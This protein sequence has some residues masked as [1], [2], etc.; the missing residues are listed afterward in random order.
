MNLAS[1]TY[2]MNKYI[3][4]LSITLLLLMVNNISAQVTVGSTNPPAE[5]SVLQLDGK[6][7]A[8]RLPQLT[9]ANILN[10]N[11]SPFDNLAKGLLIYNAS[12]NQIECWNGTDWKLTTDITVGNGLTFK[13]GKIWLGGALNRKTTINLN[14]YTLSFLTGSN[15]F[16][17]YNGVLS[18]TDKNVLFNTPD[19]S[20]GA[21]LFSVLNNGVA[22]NSNGTGKLTVNAT[23]ESSLTV[24][25]NHVTIE[26]AL[27]YYED[28][29]KPAGNQVLV[30]DYIGIGHWAALRPT[31]QVKKGTLLAAKNIKTGSNNNLETADITDSPLVL[32]PGKWLIFINYAT[33]SNLS[34]TSGNR[35][36]SARYI[37]TQLYYTDSQTT[38]PT[39]KSVIG[40]NT[41]LKETGFFAYPNMVYLVDI[42]E[43]TTYY[44]YCST[45]NRST[46]LDSTIAPFSFVAVSIVDDE[47]L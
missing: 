22:V 14:N 19:F 24:E 36:N 27:D 30:S 46:S 29:V 44:V 25:G 45:M 43:T 21:S 34:Y 10:L 7:G 40:T 39:I 20:V 17:I 31:A 42:R 12:T 1:N 41:S 47:Q 6:Q 28:G 3:H 16:N 9:T 8:L 2:N 5:F 37:W 38:T 15:K 32:T 4:I 13:E 18:V 11:V 26:G 35:D 33:K 23:K